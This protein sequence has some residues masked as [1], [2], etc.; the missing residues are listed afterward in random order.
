M[1]TEPRP[2]KSLLLLICALMACGCERVEEG[3]VIRLAHSLDEGHTVHQA[4]VFM[5]ERVAEKS[6]GKL[7]LEIYPG[8]QLGSERE[9]LELLQFGTIG[10]TKV[11]AAVMESFAPAY[12]IFGVPYLFRD[13][14][15]M[16]RVLDG[17]LGR[18][19][20]QAGRNA[21][22]LGLGYYDS[23]S[24]HFYTKDPVSS[25]ADL[26]GKKIRVMNSQSSIA[27]I[28]QMGAAPTPLPLGDLY[29]A[30]QQGVV[31]G[32]ENN[33]PSF[34]RLRHYEVCKN[35]V[36]DGHTAI[37]DVLVM[38]LPVWEGLNSEEQTWL[39]EAAQES[40]EKQRTLWQAAEEHSLERLKANGVTVQVPEP[41]VFG[42]F[43]L[44]FR[45]TLNNDAELAGWIKQVEAVQ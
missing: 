43:G 23:G 5:A 15:H 7:R 6:G 21:R 17:T 28:Q 42:E 34:E 44:R 29:T 35:L 26:E 40:V 33:L 41:S 8:G 31:D 25:P 19:V 45:E 32:A 1:R 37:P 30:L 36:L 18:E 12:R 24:R 10:M 38:S 11:S 20:L 39:R 4:M 16:V 22:L 14:Q 13:H 2:V 9:S 27:M 3:K